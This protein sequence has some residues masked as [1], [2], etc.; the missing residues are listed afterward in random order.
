[1]FLAVSAA[2]VL[3][4]FSGVRRVPLGRVCMVRSLFVI[5]GL[6]VLRSL[7]MVACSMRMVF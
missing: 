1:M 5:A 7:F 4:M 6:I 2:C 3:A